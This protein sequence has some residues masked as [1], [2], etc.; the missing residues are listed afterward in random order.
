[1]ASSPDAPMTKSVP[2]ENGEVFENKKE[3]NKKDDAPPAQPV[4]P[5]SRTC[6]VDPFSSH[7]EGEEIRKDDPDTPRS[8]LI[9]YAKKFPQKSSKLMT[10]V[11][12]NH[13]R[14]LRR[15]HLRHPGP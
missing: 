3:E 12:A 11:S 14:P 10:I 2:L 5:G 6:P 8:N 13:H 4:S 15:R 1:M 7:K 9:R